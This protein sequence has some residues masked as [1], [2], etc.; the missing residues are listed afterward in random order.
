[1]STYDDMFDAAEFLGEWDAESGIRY[2]L[3]SV[4][5]DAIDDGSDEPP[6][7]LLH[8]IDSGNVRRVDILMDLAY[9]RE[10]NRFSADRIAEARLQAPAEMAEILDEILDASGFGGAV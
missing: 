8:G 6:A 3:Y 9:Q 4:P 7:Y 1:M 2:K 5:R 10:I